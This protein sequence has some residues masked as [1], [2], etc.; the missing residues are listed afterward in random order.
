MT[1]LDIRGLAAGYGQAPILQDLSMAIHSGEVIAVLGASGS[2]KTTLLRVLAGFLTPLAG[3]VRFG[4]RLVAGD[5]TFVPPERRRIGMM[6][7]EGALFPHLTAAGNIGFGLPRGGDQR[8]QQIDDLLALVGMQGLGDR[9]PQQLSGGQQQRVALARA[10]APGPDLLCLDEPFSS[11]DASLRARLRAEVS[12]VLRSTGTTTVLVT[13]DQEEALSIAD[14]VAVLREGRLVQ[15]DTPETLYA[16]PADLDTARFV[17]EIVELDAVITPDGRA[18]TALGD[19]T[20]ADAAP[21]GA[22]GIVALRPEQLTLVAAQP[23]SGADSRTPTGRVRSTTFHGHDSITEVELPDGGLVR[24]RVPGGAHPA[25]GEN[26]GIAVP[27]PVL[28]YP[29]DR[30]RP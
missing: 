9:R 12:A 19:L 27:A 1:A 25:I 2:G 17:G 5:G 15:F 4:D 24:V 6:P 29:Q 23:I 16:R 20:L 18:A 13:H 21:R 3:T 28:F 10:L 26:V 7:Q 30:P 14:R 22:R 8:D 11:L